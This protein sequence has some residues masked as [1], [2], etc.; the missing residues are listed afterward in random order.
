VVTQT[1]C[2]GNSAAVEVLDPRANRWIRKADMPTPRHGHC[3]VALGR[4]IIVIG[5]YTD[6]GPTGVVEEY[7]TEQDRWVARAPVP[8]P[9]GF[10]AAGTVGGQVYAVAGRVRGQPPVERYDPDADR[11][12]RLDL[13]PGGDRNRFGAVVVNGKIYL[14][15]GEFQGDRTLPRSVMCFTPPRP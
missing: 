5:G 3:A 15:G 14:L 6:R 13:M 7:D 12:Q 9:R 2:G 4:R 1:A 11:W 8:T 10:F